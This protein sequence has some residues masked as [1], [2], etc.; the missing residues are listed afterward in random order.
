MN[1]AVK[2]EAIV[3]PLH[4][5]HFSSEAA[6]NAAV[7]GTIP[8]TAQ[9]IITAADERKNRNR[10]AP[11]TENTIA[12]A[13]PADSITGVIPLLNERMEIPPAA[14]HMTVTARGALMKA[15]PAA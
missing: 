15:V 12:R 11:E 9:E 6:R 5:T 13:A 7:R 1:S 4:L 8:A 3:I 2:P 14:T 10:A